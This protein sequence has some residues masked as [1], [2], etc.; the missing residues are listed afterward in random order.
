LSREDVVR[1]AESALRRAQRERRRYERG[2]VR[3]FT[4]RTRHRRL[5]VLISVG[6]VLA[7]VLAVVLVALSPALA[8]R[9][10]QVEGAGSIGSRKVE[11]ALSNQLGRP[12]AMVGNAQVK[13]DLEKFPQIQSV[14]AQAVPPRT[15]VVRIVPRVPIGVIQHGSSYD[16]VDA[17][18]VQLASST[19][20]P[21]ALPLIHITPARS[22][23]EHSVFAAVAEV[24]TSLPSAILAR[25]HTVTATTPDDV[26]FTLGASGPTVVWGTPADSG[27]KAA[28]LNRLLALPGASSATEYDV[29]APY[30][31]V[32]R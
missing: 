23:T 2:E 28:D 25:V 24:L 22:A 10:I 29:S 1:D 6:V 17:A 16:T 12:L 32:V 11:D 20:R 4:R 7:V 30:S 9:T 5:V 15:L 31:V 27:L 8:L 3:R 21:A 13:A 18:H 26:T 19:T 14:S